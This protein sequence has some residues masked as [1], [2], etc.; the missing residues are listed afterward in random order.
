MRAELLKNTLKDLFY[1]K[2]AVMVESEPGGGKTEIVGQV[3]KEL[4]VEFIHKHI[5]TM[6]VEDFGIPF[7][8]GDALTYKIQS[9]FP[10]NPEWTGILSITFLRDTYPSLLLYDCIVLITCLIIFSVS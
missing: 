8:T 9:W 10:R 7:P 5:P 1:S 3:A 4:G 6:L 2:R